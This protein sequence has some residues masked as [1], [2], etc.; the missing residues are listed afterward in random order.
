M[1]LSITR[2]QSKGFTGNVSF[3]VRV[4]LMPT[5]EEANLISHY[6]LANEVVTISNKSSAWT[7]RL[8][9]VKIRDVVDGTTFKAKDLREVIDYSDTVEAVAESLMQ[10]LDVARRF[11]GEEITEIHLPEDD[12]K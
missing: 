3:E 8:K 10:Y 1:K 4:K 5:A 2:S 11:G 7:G 9:D 12:V 6:K